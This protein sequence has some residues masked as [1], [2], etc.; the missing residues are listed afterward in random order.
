MAKIGYARVSSKTQNLDRQLEALKGVSKI[1]SDKYSGN[2]VD[3][4]ELQAMLNYIREGDIIVVTE[5]GSVIDLRSL[6]IRPSEI[7]TP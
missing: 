6:K 1:F 5:L 2:S 3:R 7:L 4:P